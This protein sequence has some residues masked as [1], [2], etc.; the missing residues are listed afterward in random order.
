[1]EGS[2]FI[3]RTGETWRA[4]PTLAGVYL[5]QFSFFAFRPSAGGNHNV[6]DKFKHIVSKLVS[7]PESLKIESYDGYSV[8]TG[9]FKIISGDDPLLFAE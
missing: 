6:P 8:P 3:L 1:M 7:A 2:D 9:R 5:E 4:H